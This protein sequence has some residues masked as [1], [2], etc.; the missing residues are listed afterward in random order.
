M[1]S[2][3]NVSFRLYHDIL[4]MSDLSLN[5]TAFPLTAD[6]GEQSLECLSQTHLKH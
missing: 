5:S 2:W 4:G 1:S 3:V 6:I